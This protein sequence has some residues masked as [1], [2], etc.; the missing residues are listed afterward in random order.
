MAAAI[1]AAAAEMNIKNGMGVAMNVLNITHRR[2]SERVHFAILQQFSLKQTIVPSRWLWISARRT[3][4]IIIT[5]I[6]WEIVFVIIICMHMR[7]VGCYH[8]QMQVHFN[9]QV[10]LSR[11]VNT[12]IMNV[13]IIMYVLLHMQ[14]DF[15]R[16]TCSAD[17]TQFLYC[18]CIYNNKYLV[19]I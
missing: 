3:F 18:I 7:K 2:R 4:H 15:T 14:N 1:E 9:A 19:K 17:N 11:I 8:W 16:C 10:C 13:I 5:I 12:I 6:E